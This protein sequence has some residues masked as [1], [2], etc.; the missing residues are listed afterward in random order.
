M[1]DINVVERIIM[2]PK[3]QSMKV[4]ANLKWLKIVFTGVMNLIIIL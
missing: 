4:W 2:D 3:K 1:G